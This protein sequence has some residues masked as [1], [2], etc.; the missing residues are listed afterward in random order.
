[1]TGTTSI[2]DQNCTDNFELFFKSKHASSLFL[3]D[4]TPFRCSASLFT[5]S[6][7]KLAYLDRIIHTSVVFSS[8]HWSCNVTFA[9]NSNYLL[10]ELIDNNID[11]PLVIDSAESLN[12]ISS[13][14]E[15]SQIRVYVES[16]FED[17]LAGEDSNPN[18]YLEMPFIPAFFVQAKQIELPIVKTYTGSAKP[19]CSDHFNL[20]IHATHQ[21]H[22]HLILTTN[23]PTFIQI[24]PL[25]LKSTKPDVSSLLT[26][27]YD[28]IT[29]ADSFDINAYTALLQQQKGELYVQIACSLTQQVER[30]P[31]KFLFN[32]GEKSRDVSSNFYRKPSSG[33]MRSLLSWFDFSQNEMLSFFILVM[34]TLMTV[35]FVLRIKTP[36]Q[37]RA[38]QMALNV[39]AATAAAVAANA[40]RQPRGVVDTFNPY[41]YFSGSPEA[42]SSDYLRSRDTRASGRTLNMSGSVQNISPLFRSPQRQQM[43]RDDQTTPSTSTSIYHQTPSRISPAERDGVTLFSPK[44]ES[45]Q[46]FSPRNTFITY[47]NDDSQFFPQRRNVPRSNQYDY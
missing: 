32:L 40:Y 8:Q 20:V 33:M 44:D 14:N 47:D 30:I 4:L 26:I 28:I 10:Y 37:Q 3:N 38:E 31:I 46:P 11:R 13:S 27:T 24:K 5:K 23:C 16:K 21:L 1:M 18:K 2:A 36:S 17:S 35:L 15:P 7:T 43:S 42:P 9:P 39:S 34:V 41:R 25:N 6:G 12:K 19:S 22:S 45:S 29:S